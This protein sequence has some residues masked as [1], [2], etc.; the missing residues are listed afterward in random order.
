MLRQYHLNIVRLNMELLVDNL[1]LPLLALENYRL[2]FFYA[3]V[4]NS[5]TKLA[6]INA[7][8]SNISPWD[9]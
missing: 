9:D 7:M 6:T 1:M 3:F 4:A 5:G 2:R 8:L